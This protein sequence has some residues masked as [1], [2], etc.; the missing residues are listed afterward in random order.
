M[1]WTCRTLSLLA[2]AT[3]ATA[4]GSMAGAA[5]AGPVSDATIAKCGKALSKACD[6]KP[7]AEHEG[8]FD[9]PNFALSC[10]FDCDDAYETKACQK[11]ANSPYSNFP[12]AHFFKAREDL[13][14][15]DFDD[16]ESAELCNAKMQTYCGFSHGKKTSLT[17]EKFDGD[18][19]CSEACRFTLKSPHCKPYM[20]SE[21]EVLTVEQCVKI[22][23]KK[24][25]G[26]VG[27]GGGGGKAADKPKEL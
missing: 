6:L 1:S 4:K 11:W 22:K 16:D 17:P 25:V 26:E 19:V 23:G 7:S 10:G 14:V 21:E 5:A 8:W 13:C 18:K 2:L 27:M 15:Y 9:T 24:G 3:T 20:N 12:H